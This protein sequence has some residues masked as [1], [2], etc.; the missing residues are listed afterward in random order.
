MRVVVDTNVLISAIFFSGAPAQL[1]AAWQEGR[2][3][4]VASA[5]IVDEYTRV[6]NELARRYPRVHGAAALAVVVAHLDL[7]EPVE[8]G[9]AVCEDPDDDKFLAC[10]LAARESPEPGF[11]KKQWFVKKHE[12]ADGERRSARRFVRALQ[13]PPHVARRRCGGGVRRCELA[14]VGAVAKRCGE[15]WCVTA[16]G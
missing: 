1:L 5:E 4:L 13:G 2:L 10:A 16:F 6:V 7:V 15:R 12:A 3:R 14:R 11:V 8:L 9:E